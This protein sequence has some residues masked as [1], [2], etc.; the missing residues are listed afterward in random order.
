M[1]LK[2]PTDKKRFQRKV[3]V[4]VLLVLL[5]IANL[6]WYYFDWR[7]ELQEYEK[8]KYEQSTITYGTEELSIIQGVLGASPNK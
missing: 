7:R 2:E 4:L 8:Y 1:K 3:W 6:V 5:L